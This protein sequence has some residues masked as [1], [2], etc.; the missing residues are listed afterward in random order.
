VSICIVR[1]RRSASTELPTASTRP[2]RRQGSPPLYSCRKHRRLNQPR[3]PAP[4]SA[5]GLRTAKF[6]PL[7]KQPGNDPDTGDAGSASDVTTTLEPSRA[8]GSARWVTACRPHVGAAGP[9]CGPC[10]QR[11]S[12]FPPRPTPRRDQGSGNPGRVRRRLGLHVRARARHQ[13]RAERRQVG[14]GEVDFRL[15]GGRSRGL[16][17]QLELAGNIQ[18]N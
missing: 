17:A 11:S 13:P 5:R 14:E 12:G 1:E 2:F 15:V 18:A 16:H 3:A 8:P 6:R 10:R 4:P 9:V 7:K